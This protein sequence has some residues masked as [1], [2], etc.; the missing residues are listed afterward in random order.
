METE[1]IH[2]AVSEDG[3]RIA[4]R[5]VG[6]GPPLVFVS[7]PLGDDATSWPAVVPWLSEQFSC[8]LMST[9]GRGL[10][11]PHS[12]HSYQRL[13]ED[14]IAYS[15]SIGTPVGLVAHSAAATLALDAAVR[16]PEVSAAALYEPTLLEFAD[17]EFMSTVIEGFG[18]VASLTEQERY[19]DGAATF[20]TDIAGA[21]DD[22]ME[23]ITRLGFS[24][25][26]A[27]NL[28]V[29]LEEFAHDGAFRLSDP[30]VLDDVTVPVVML[31][32]SRSPRHYRR[33]SELLE[34]RLAR[35]VVREL[36][37]LGHF[38]PLVAAYPVAAELGTFFASA[39][40]RAIRM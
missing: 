34:R 12:D 38:A 22:E 15:E 33:Y 21:T 18:R 31:I 4:G 19:A 35:P 20:L 11:E 3:T 6:K 9:R 37:G 25:R 28:R 8:H 1:L 24:E 17:E 27:H 16:S 5:V 36:D 26:D 2:S 14:V 23:A 30:A 39:M 32:G 7:S 10:S 13:L 40:Q 29:L